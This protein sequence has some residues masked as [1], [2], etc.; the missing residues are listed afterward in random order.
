VREE[1]QR[2]QQL[3]GCPPEAHRHEHDHGQQRGDGTV[4]ADERGQQR[5]DEHHQHQ[6]ARAA[7]ARPRDQALADP[8]RDARRVE[9]LADHE[10]GRDEQDRGIAEAR[11]DLVEREHPG[12]PEGQRRPDGD[13]LH[14]EA[15][16]YEQDDDRRDDRERDGDVVHG[17]VR[18]SAPDDDV[19][20]DHS[21]MG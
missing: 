3:R 14:R 17:R 2:H 12:R 1:H 15:A 19:A 13:H 20:G 6:E 5:H 16:P 8:R 9:C 10:Q 4:D 21:W 7:I 11:Q 18:E